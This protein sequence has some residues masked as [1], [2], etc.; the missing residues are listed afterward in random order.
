METFPIVAQQPKA[1]IPVRAEWLRVPDAMHA[2]GI[3]RSLLY[4]LIR[5]RKIKSVCL[6]KRNAQRGIRLI[7]ADSL[8]SFIESAANSGDAEDKR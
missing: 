3:G 4:E 5:E 7:N 2:S 6:R 1:V 8:N